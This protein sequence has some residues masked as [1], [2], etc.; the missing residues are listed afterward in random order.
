MEARGRTYCGAAQSAKVD[1]KAP[2]VFDPRVSSSLVGHLIGAVNG[3]SIARKTS[4]GDRLGQQ[5]FDKTSALS[6]TAARAGMRSQAFG[7]VA[8]RNAIIDEGV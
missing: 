6:T 8:T 4:L 7:G 5:L 2:V 1:R 3:A